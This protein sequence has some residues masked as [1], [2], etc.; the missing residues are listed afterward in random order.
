MDAQ[1][2]RIKAIAASEGLELIGIVDDS[3]KSAFDMSRE[4]LNAILAAAAAR[5]FDVVIVR[6]WARLARDPDDLQRI[7][8]SLAAGGV[9]VVQGAE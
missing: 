1:A 4:G 3:G 7:L 9:I 8:D 6:D 2:A 5:R